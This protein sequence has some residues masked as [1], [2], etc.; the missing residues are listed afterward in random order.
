MFFHGF[1][2]YAVQVKNDR[3]KAI[4]ESQ[5]GSYVES[6][7]YSPEEAIKKVKQKVNILRQDQF[8]SL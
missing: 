7:S 1:L 2:I 6:Y 3:W 5:T 8:A 4:A